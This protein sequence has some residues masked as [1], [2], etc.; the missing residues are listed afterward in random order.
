VADGLNPFR[1][2]GVFEKSGKGRA[3]DFAATFQIDHDS[4]VAKAFE[5]SELDSSNPLHRY[6]LLKL[7][8]GALFPPDRR[9]RKTEWT[10]ERLSRLLSDYDQTRQ[11][12]PRSWNDTK[13]TVAMTKQHEHYRKIKPETIRRNLAR[14]RD[15]K[16]NSDVAECAESIRA[17]IMS[18]VPDLKMS[19]LRLGKMATEFAIQWLSKRWEREQQLTR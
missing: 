10:A 3:I 17:I 7:L 18:E 11:K 2:L 9:G 19:D 12:S 15:P 1:Q 14:A 13:I 6:R 5:R 4:P 16:A 8:A